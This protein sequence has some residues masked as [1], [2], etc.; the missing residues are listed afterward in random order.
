MTP[1]ETSHHPHHLRFQRAFSIVEVLATMVILTLGIIGTYGFIASAQKTSVSTE[2]RILAIN[3]AREGIEAVENIRNTN[4]LKFSSDY[5]NCWKVRNYDT[6]CV[7]NNNP[8][9]FPA[10][11]YI[12]A[13]NNG[14]FTL[15]GTITPSSDYPTYHDQFAIY[16]D[17]N[18]LATQTGSYT[19]IC[20]R[21]FPTS[22]KSI[23]S[24][25][26]TLTNPSPDTLLVDSIVTWTDTRSTTP[27]RIDM[28]STLTNWKKNATVT[29]DNEK[30]PIPPILVNVSA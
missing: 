26:I 8:N 1:A 12:V 19:Q 6:T 2:N 15:S 20:N 11:S 14:L 17:A 28:P 5:N 4:W 9:I 18:G 13:M 3:I 23:F 7:G 27:S 24:R 21:T 25:E 22:C 29:E 10:G 30:S 16:F